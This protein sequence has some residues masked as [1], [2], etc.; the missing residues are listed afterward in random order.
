MK[1]RIL[2]IVLVL[3]ALLALTACQQQEQYPNQPRQETVQQEPAPQEPVQQAAA[4]Q[5]DF[6]DG[7]YNPASE[8]DE[9]AEQVYDS[10]ITP[11][12][13]MKSEYAG[14]TPVKIDPVDKP[15]P[16][17]LPTLSFSYATYTAS[18]LR[19][20]FDGPAGWLP[21]DS[22]A[23]TYTLSYPNQSM[24]Y[25]AK[26]VI[27]TVNVG[28]NYTQKDLTKEVKAQADAVRSSLGFKT[29]EPSQTATRRFIDDG[30]V[31]IAYKGTLNDE[32]ETGVAGR[33][34]VN[35]VNKILYIMHVSYPKGLADTFA[36]GVYN[37]VRHTLKL[38]N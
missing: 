15:T 13:T 30:G 26:V 11:A 24:D 20:T 4:Q 17:P 25:E 22:A 33:I 21:D 37:K 1:K 32:N 2:C 10:G 34:I 36:D 6:N 14:A 7:S 23:D 9:V 28:K 29:F 19:L 16:T 3:C 35:T 38:A 27:R 18:N 5:I 8:E 12:P 31:Y